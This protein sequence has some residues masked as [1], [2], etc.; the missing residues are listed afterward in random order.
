[1]PSPGKLASAGKLNVTAKIKGA[2]VSRENIRRMTKAVRKKLFDEIVHISA[3]ILDHSKKNYVPELSGDLKRS[4]RL[5]KH[6]GRYPTVEIGFGG[7]AVDYAVLQH[8]NPFFNHPRGGS[9]KYLEFA[10]RDFE[11]RIEGAIK[12]ALQATIIKY[13]MRGKVAI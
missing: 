10:V 2:R 6:P 8:E 9:Y 3:Q 7:A 5:V 4:G 1:M 13:D 11:P 12:T